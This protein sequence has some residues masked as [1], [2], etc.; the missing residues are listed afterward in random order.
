[1]GKNKFKPVIVLFYE[2]LTLVGWDDGVNQRFRL[3]YDLISNHL[4]IENECD[5][6]ERTEK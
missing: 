1:M 5:Q 2:E 3:I 4:W 6:T